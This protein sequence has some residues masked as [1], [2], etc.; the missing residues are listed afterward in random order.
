VGLRVDTT[1]LPQDVLVAIRTLVELTHNGQRSSIMGSGYVVTAN[2][3]KLI[4]FTRNG[5]TVEIVIA[6]DKTV[7]QMGI[8]GRQQGFR[9]V[10]IVLDILDHRANK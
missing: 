9:F 3:K 4:R 6:A 5:R 1:S 2:K 10:K 8:Y 7:A